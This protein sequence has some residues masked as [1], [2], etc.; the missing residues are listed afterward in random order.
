MSAAFDQ[1]VWAKRFAQSDDGV[2]FNAGAGIVALRGTVQQPRFHEFADPADPRHAE[3]ATR[4]Q[5]PSLSEHSEPAKLSTL[6][7]INDRGF[8]G[9]ADAA[10]SPIGLAPANFGEDVPQA[11]PTALTQLAR[12]P[13]ADVADPR[14]N[15]A[16]DE[17]TSTPTEG[18]EDED[19]FFFQNGPRSPG[20]TGVGAQGAIPGERSIASLDA[21]DP[22]APFGEVGTAE[23]DLGQE[24]AKYGPAED[25]ATDGVAFFITDDG[26]HG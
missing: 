19:T 25:I 10:L 24:L 9:D 13:R 7:S 17:A 22:L 8:A 20:E 11:M 26:L 16:A 18:L 2:V 14:T 12:A 21:L 1:Y 6:A 5:A 3:L 15:P 23:T 4:S